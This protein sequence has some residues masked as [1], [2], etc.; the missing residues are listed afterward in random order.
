MEN[1]ANLL[2]LLE[3]LHLQ[4][5]KGVGI[6][7]HTHGVERTPRVGDITVG[8]GG[9]VGLSSTHQDSLDRKDSQDGLGVDQT[10]AAKVVQTG[11]NRVS[12]QTS[13]VPSVVTR[14]LTSQ[15]VVGG[16]SRVGAQPLDTSST[17]P[18]GGGR[19]HGNGMGEWANWAM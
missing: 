12:S 5:S 17:V 11:S 2:E 13:G 16:P 4:L 6:F 14:E 3:L 10:L 18:G 15:V 8:V 19:E 1:I 7:R 9:T